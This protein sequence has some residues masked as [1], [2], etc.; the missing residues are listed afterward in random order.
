MQ[1]TALVPLTHCAG[2]PGGGSLM[3][4]LGRGSSRGHPGVLGRRLLSAAEQKP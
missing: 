4:V 2:F 1:G 3:P